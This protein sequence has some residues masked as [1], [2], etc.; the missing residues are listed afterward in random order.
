MIR[1][2]SLVRLH[3]DVWSGDPALNRPAA[4]ASD[5]DVEAFAR[6]LKLA[7]ESG[8]WTD[9][10]REGQQPT[11]FT[12]KPLRGAVYRKVKDLLDLK[13]VGDEELKALVF[14]ATIV[15]IANFD[16]FKISKT[17]VDGFGELASIDV[18]DALDTLTP[19]IVNELGTAAYM[20]AMRG[21]PP[22]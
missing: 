9:V 14:R 20:R 15:D 18:T 2:P 22:L 4:D 10:I 11:R 19:R 12:F 8:I 7:R 3:E 21:V 16:D 6:R 5:A 17:T 1:P 13:T